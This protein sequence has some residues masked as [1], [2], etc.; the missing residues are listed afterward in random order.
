MRGIDNTEVGKEKN[1]RRRNQAEST[2]LFVTFWA[3]G[4]AHRTLREGKNEASERYTKDSLKI[5]GSF[6][7]TTL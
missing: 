3:T 1:R 4:E 7:I 2:E 6:F 5:T